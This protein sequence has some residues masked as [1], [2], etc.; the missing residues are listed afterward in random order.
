MNPRK[1]EKRLSQLLDRTDAAGMGAGSIYKIRLTN[2]R[3]LLDKII[4]VDFATTQQ[5]NPEDSP[6]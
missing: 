3:Y 2:L 5:D 4:L 1:I 6:L